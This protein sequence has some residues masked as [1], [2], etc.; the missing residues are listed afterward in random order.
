M[1]ESATMKKIIGEQD[2]ALLSKE[3]AAIKQLIDTVRAEKYPRINFA[4]AS[5]EQISEV[6]GRNFNV[7]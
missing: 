1:I 3:L 2:Y 5:L 6:T 4:K 7:G